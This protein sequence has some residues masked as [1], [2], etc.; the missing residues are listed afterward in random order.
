MKFATNVQ[1][2]NFDYT[3]QTSILLLSSS[4]VVGF[5]LSWLE[6]WKNHKL[7]SKMTGYFLSS[8]FQNIPKRSRRE[9]YFL[10]NWIFLLIVCVSLVTPSVKVLYSK[11]DHGVKEEGEAHHLV[12]EVINTDICLCFFFR[13][14]LEKVNKFFGLVKSLLHFY[15]KSIVFVLKILK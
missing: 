5:H 14:V 11:E 12:L 9:N 10:K 1:K 7:L 15:W 4:R 8:T 2:Q 3:N 13:G 6:T